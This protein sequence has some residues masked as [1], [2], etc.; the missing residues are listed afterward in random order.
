M[1]QIQRAGV[2][3]KLM[4]HLLLRVRQREIITLVDLEAFLVWLEQKPEVPEGNWYKRFS[5]FI[6]CGE[7]PLVKTFLTADQTAIGEEVA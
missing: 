4:E 1:P 2:P 3:R 7:G 5:A 6:A